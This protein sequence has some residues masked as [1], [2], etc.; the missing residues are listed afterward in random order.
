M[1]STPPRGRVSYRSSSRRHSPSALEAAT[2]TDGLVDPTL[3]AALM[4]AGYDRDF[5]SSDGRRAASSSRQ[6]GRWKDGAPYGSAVTGRGDAARP[7]RRR[8]G[9]RRRR[10]AR[11]PV[12]PRLR[13]RRRRPRG[14]RSGR[15]RAA[16]RRRVRSSSGGIATS[17]SVA[18]R[19]LRGGSE[20][21]H[22]IDPITGA[23]SRSPWAQVS[24]VG[25]TCLAADVC[26]K[27]AFLLGEDG[28]AWLDAHGAA[29]SLPTSEGVSRTTSGTRRSSGRRAC[30]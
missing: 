19:W 4:A 15:R 6:P 26:A 3:G 21:H 22:L 16:G 9:P 2:A 28:P 30:T 18:R 5:A 10:R 13:L 27:A 17:G 23:P 29:G 24:V 7:E 12:G 25:A 20:Q 11:A 8:Q 1:R 14:E